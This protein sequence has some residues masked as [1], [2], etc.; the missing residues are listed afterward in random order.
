MWFSIIMTNLR[1]LGAVY[2][3]IFM[4][5]K[6]TE[7][8]SVWITKSKEASDKIWVEPLVTQCCRTQELLDCKIDILTFC[9]LCNLSFLLN[10]TDHDVTWQSV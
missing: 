4:L 8:M 3:T 2:I 7:W 10:H 9:E 6:L 1:S 5:I